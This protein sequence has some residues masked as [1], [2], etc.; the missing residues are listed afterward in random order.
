MA[1]PVH[2]AVRGGDYTF[3]NLPDALAPG[4]TLFSF[5]NQGLVRHELSIGL[6][7]PGVTIDQVKKEGPPAG[8]FVERV[9]GILIARPGDSAGGQLLIDLAPGRTYLVQCTLKDA[10]DAAPHSVLGMV[11]S[12]VVPK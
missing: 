8:R 2:V 4:R 12:F 3:L 6:L 10:P 1:E 5:S 11:G 9:A 7:R